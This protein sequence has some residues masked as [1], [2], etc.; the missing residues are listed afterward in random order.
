MLQAKGGLEAAPERAHPSPTPPAPA[1][2]HAHS[3]HRPA[4]AYYFAI[5]S[6]IT[7]VSSSVK[8]R[9]LPLGRDAGP[10]CFSRKRKSVA[11]RSLATAQPAPLAALQAFFTLAPR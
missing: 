7:R 2:P 3:L 9:I 1:P 4:R 8:G 10:S 6:N 5:F 11:G